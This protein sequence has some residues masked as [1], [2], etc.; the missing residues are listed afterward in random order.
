MPVL[1]NPKHE[2]YA[3][4]LAKGETE[5]SAYVAV[6]YKPDDGNASKL[7]RNVRHRAQEITGKGG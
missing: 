5:A 6:G 3:Q 2:L 4:R 1:K 7:A